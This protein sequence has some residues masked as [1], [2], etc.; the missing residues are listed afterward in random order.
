M[1]QMKE[2]KKLDDKGEP[3]VSLG[4]SYSI[5]AYKLYNPISKMIVLRRDVVIDE[6]GED[7]KSVV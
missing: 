6:S 1:H 7:R 5:G 2:K 3:V 4:Y